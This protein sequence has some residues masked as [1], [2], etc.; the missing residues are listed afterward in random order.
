MVMLKTNAISRIMIVLLILFILSGCATT[1]GDWKVAQSLNTGNAYQSFLKKHPNSEFSVEAERLFQNV[2]IKEDWKVA[3]SLNTGNAYQSFCS[4]HPNSEFS[5]EAERCYKN[6]SLAE[7]VLQMAPPW[8]TSYTRGQVNKPW[9][10]EISQNLLIPKL[11]QLLI[12]GAD[13]NAVK[14]SGYQPII[15]K[16]TT[17]SNG[18]NTSISPG[19]PGTLVSSDENGQT[20]LSFCQGLKLLKAATLL[21]HHGAK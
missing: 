7:I 18:Y 14:I 20:L 17:S 2:T 1:K 3:K 11:E 16:T 10:P 6:T 12:G 21:I 15:T 5:A 13:P 9:D 4:M 8:Q 19:S